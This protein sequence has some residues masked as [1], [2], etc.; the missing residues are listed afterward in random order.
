MVGLN[1]P[2]SMIGGCVS[3]SRRAVLHDVLKAKKQGAHGKSNKQQRS[4]KRAALQQEVED[5][6]DDYS[7]RGEV[8]RRLGV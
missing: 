8:P 4:N 5:A 7:N 6:L 2:M 1:L 3:N